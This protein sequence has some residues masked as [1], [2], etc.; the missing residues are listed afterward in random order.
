MEA[1]ARRPA[2]QMLV[3]R[4]LAAGGG[5]QEREGGEGCRGAVSLVK[6]WLIILLIL[7]TSNHTNLIIFSILDTSNHAKQII[8]LGGG[9]AVQAPTFKS[10]PT[11][12]PEGSHRG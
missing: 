2:P 7:V 12:P 6:S 11:I 8:L 9:A 1:M 5:A 4:R 3:E 10:P